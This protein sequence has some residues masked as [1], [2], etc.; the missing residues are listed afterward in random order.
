MRT[1]SHL[2]SLYRVLERLCACADGYFCLKVESNSTQTDNSLTFFVL[3]IHPFL[4]LAVHCFII[5]INN[6][7]AWA[8]WSVPRQLS[9]Q[10]VMLVI[11]SS[12]E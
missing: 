9:S 2:M 6:F 12:L 4:R 8:N 3:S 11:F 5:I 7:K 1:K 10:L